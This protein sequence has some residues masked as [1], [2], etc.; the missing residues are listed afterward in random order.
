M[1]HQPL[2]SMHI[3]YI[4]TLVFMDVYI[5]HCVIIEIVVLFKYICAY[6]VVL[7]RDLLNAMVLDFIE[8]AIDPLFPRR[9][10]FSRPPERP[11]NQFERI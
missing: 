1:E 7:F 10:Q 6:A 9:A 2:L 8:I 11:A 5:R 4:V 3:R